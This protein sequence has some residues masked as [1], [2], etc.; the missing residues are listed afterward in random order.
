MATKTNPKGKGARQQAVRRARIAAAA[1]T[2]RRQERR[3]RWVMVAILAAFIAAVVLGAFAATRDRGSKANVAAN[4]TGAS[5][6]AMTDTP[7][8]GAPYVPV[9]VGPAPTQLVTEELR[10]GTGDDVV[11]AGDAV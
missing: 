4:E 8:V 10:A 5:C 9:H 7:P 3:K 1:Q 2:E 6:V 11:Q